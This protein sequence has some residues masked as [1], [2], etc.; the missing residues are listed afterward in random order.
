MSLQEGVQA[1]EGKAEGSA[2]GTAEENAE[3]DDDA[4]NIF[5]LQLTSRK[6]S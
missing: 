6:L 2:E 4:G 5:R 1:A 3:D